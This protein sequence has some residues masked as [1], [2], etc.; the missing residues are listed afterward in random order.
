MKTD[1][2][3][4]IQTK[5]ALLE[6]I[7]RHHA[8]SS[9][10]E[11]LVTAADALVFEEIHASAPLTLGRTVDDTKPSDAIREAPRDHLIPAE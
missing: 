3:E 7:R 2:P 8:I 9:N 1:L 6:E 10:T 5:P 4:V 11:H